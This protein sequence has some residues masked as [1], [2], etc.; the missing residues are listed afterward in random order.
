MRT[1]GG[2]CPPCPPSLPYAP[3][4]VQK[5]G[6]AC[7]YTIMVRLRT[8]R[9]RV[10]V[11]YTDFFRIPPFWQCPF[12]RTTACDLMVQLSVTLSDPEHQWRVYA[13]PIP[14]VCPSVR[15]LVY[16]IKT[17][18]RIIE[19]LSPSDRPIILV[20]HHQGSLCKSEGVTPNG[21]AKYKGVAI[22]DQYAPISRKQ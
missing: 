5:L 13:T 9:F 19:I 21:G 17:A 14:S 7:G 3:G 12:L 1:S 4:N 18:E 20:F 6:F 8:C 2:T 22:F 15:T 11:R 10:M 16:C